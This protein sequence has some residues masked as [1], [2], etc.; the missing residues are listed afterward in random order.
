M[1]VGVADS[2][3]MVK[4]IKQ[5]FDQTGAPASLDIFVLGGVIVVGVDGALEAKRDATPQELVPAK[6]VLLG[7]S[8]LEM[9]E[10]RGGAWRRRVCVVRVV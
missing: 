10:M 4:V 8:L 5:K 1:D 2:P 3:D 7:D 9:S 6:Y